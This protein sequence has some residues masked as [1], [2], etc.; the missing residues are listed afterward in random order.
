VAAGGLFLNGQAA[1]VFGEVAGI[2]QPGRAAVGTDE[3]RR[4]V[5]E[6]ALLAEILHVGHEPPGAARSGSRLMGRVQ[7]SV[8]GS[9]LVRPFGR[10]CSGLTVS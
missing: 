6:I 1:S 9:R 4:D 5:E 7:F 3:L 10:G 8:V 2:A